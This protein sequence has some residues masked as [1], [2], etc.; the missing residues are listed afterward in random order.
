MEYLLYILIFFVVICIT[1]NVDA[2]SFRVDPPILTFVDMSV[3]TLI[4]A[5]WFPLQSYFY[6]RLPS[7]FTDDMEAGFTSTNFDLAANV[8]DGDVRAGLN[9]QAKHEIR[10][11][12]RRRKLGFDE[13]RQ[14]YMEQRFARE[15]ILPD[16]RPRDPKL[17]SFS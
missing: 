16:G 6:E 2:A 7:T 10:K 12:M 13:A 14:A 9:K 1:G 15:N 17:V 3:I 8:E 4:R 11:I 5:R